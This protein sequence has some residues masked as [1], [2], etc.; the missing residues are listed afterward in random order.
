[1]SAIYWSSLKSGARFIDICRLF[2]LE[3]D[4]AE[5]VRIYL[6]QALSP[7]SIE[8]LWINA[9]LVLYGDD[10]LSFRCYL[11]RCRIYEYHFHNSI[12]GDDAVTECIVNLMD[13][14]M[15][16]HYLQGKIALIENLFW[17]DTASV[18]SQRVGSAFIDLLTRLGL[19]VEACIN[20]ELE[21]YPGG[22][23]KSWYPYGVDRR[24]VFDSLQNGGWILGWTWDHD[25]LAAGHI[26]V[27]EH[28]AL[29]ADNFYAIGWPFSRYHKP[30]KVDAR[31]ER[32]EAAKARKERA[33][34]GQKRTKSKMPGTWSW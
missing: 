31:R 26:L 7:K 33:R 29:G 17:Y 1:M 3:C 16:Q 9:G 6:V 22:L 24:I 19:D 23:I 18:K 13:E 4:Q 27:S 25:P 8:W 21:N 28:I 34:T 2:L 10:L 12:W 11:L 32:R 5:D 14:E 20:M 30:G 15:I